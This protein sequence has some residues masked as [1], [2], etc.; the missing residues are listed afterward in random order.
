MKFQKQK[1]PKEQLIP[2]SVE[3]FLV[4]EDNVKTELWKMGVVDNWLHS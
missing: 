1:Y 4:H 3:K 2:E